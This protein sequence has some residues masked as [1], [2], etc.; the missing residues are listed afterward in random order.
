M[1]SEIWCH[2][3]SD[4]P[5]ITLL[6]LVIV[7][8]I[9]NLAVQGGKLKTA[10]DVVQPHRSIHLRRVENEP[11]RTVSSYRSAMVNNTKIRDLDGPTTL[12][13]PAA[14]TVYSKDAGD[15]ESLL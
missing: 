2:R 14:T 3:R 8:A 7:A 5:A 4:W 6:G 10:A 11:P 9:L 12:G 1:N 13:L 15:D